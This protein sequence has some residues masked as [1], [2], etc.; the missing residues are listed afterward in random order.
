MS[1]TNQN[2]DGND[3]NASAVPETSH[4]SR[5][6]DCPHLVQVRSA[7]CCSWECSKKNALALSAATY[8]AG[9]PVP[10]IVRIVLWECEIEDVEIDTW[11]R[12]RLL[13]RAGET[14][15]PE[16]ERVF[17]AVRP[18]VSRCLT[19]RCEDPRDV[20]DGPDFERSIGDLIADAH[21]K[22]DEKPKPSPITP[23]SEPAPVPPDLTPKAKP[24][25]KRPRRAPVRD[26]GWGRD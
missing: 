1:N 18:R 7:G 6:H 17:E 8:L 14:P 16:D 20:V 5:P 10:E 22:D 21:A 2:Q 12:V 9:V 3:Q 4:P 11:D 24:K 25:P 13:K 15:T 19:C 26:G 23:Q